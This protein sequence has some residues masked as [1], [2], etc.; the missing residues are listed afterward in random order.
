MARKKYD[1]LECFE[2]HKIFHSKLS[3][4]RRHLKLHGPKIC[5][6]KCTQCGRSFQTLSNYKT[7]FKN[8]NSSCIPAEP[9][10]VEDSPKGNIFFIY[11]FDT[12][13]SAFGLFRKSCSCHQFF[14]STSYY[15]QS[16]NRSCRFRN[17]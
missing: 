1:L 13:S 2:C 9:E 17:S 5:Q 10:Y 4:L 11:T 16:S 7:H 8:I 3:N 6:V 15:N 12:I 14:C